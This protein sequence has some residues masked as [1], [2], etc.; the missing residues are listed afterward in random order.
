MSKIKIFS[1]A[2]AFLLTSAF[3]YSWSLSQPK[4]N[5]GLSGNIMSTVNVA[6]L[7]EAITLAVND[8][9][10]IL[11]VLNAG[12]Q[13]IDTINLN[14][15]TPNRYPDAADAFVD[16]GRNRLLD[17]ASTEK[18]KNTPWEEL[19]IPISV[20]DKS[21]AAGTNYKAHME[22]MGLEGN[23]PFLFPKLSRATSWDAEVTS[24]VRLD[25]EVELCALPIA[26]FSAGDT[27]E[28]A[29]L[30]CGDFTDRWLLVSDMDLG[31][32]MGKT[33]FPLGKGGATRMPV[34]PFLV[35][36]STHD[37]YKK[38]DLKLYVNSTLR[39]HSKADLM[40]WNPSEIME[41]T[42]RDCESVYKRLD[43]ELGILDNCEKIPAKTLF[44]TGTPEGVM[45]HLGTIWNPA[46]Y[47]RSGDVITA[48]AT[49][50]GVTKNSVN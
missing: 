1:I 44:L 29:Y 48:S 17:I 40:I 32:E 33:G 43:E 34:G 16:L 38:I 6:P 2:S 45:F 18:T 35:F 47:L 50:L 30:L 28:M 3:L 8:A 23:P 7:T 41:H 24:G 12:E 25:H 10:E 21:I 39:Q 9:G 31:G 49:Y 26:D 36:P 46:F 20:T 42:L 14:D 15:L 22:E 11:L 19:S 5:E 27:V 4:F 37:F 13:G